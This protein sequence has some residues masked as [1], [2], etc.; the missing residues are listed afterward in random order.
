MLS[1]SIFN[2]NTLSNPTTPYMV[3]VL[4]DS[5][6]KTSVS[7][8]IVQSKFTT[9]EVYQIIVVNLVTLV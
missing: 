2:V 3:K 7:A 1:Q 8:N 4:L 5:S 6:P 9:N